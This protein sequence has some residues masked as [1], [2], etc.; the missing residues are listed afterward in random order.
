MLRRVRS[1]PADDPLRIALHVPLIRVL[2][3]EEVVVVAVAH[4]GEALRVEVV[5]HDPF[6]FEGPAQCS[7]VVVAY[8]G[9]IGDRKQQTAD[10]R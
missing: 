4:E 8:R 1:I 2:V 10:K 9:Q 3:K 5:I 6:V 7:V